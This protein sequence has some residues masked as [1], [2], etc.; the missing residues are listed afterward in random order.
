MAN[1]AT[2]MGNR[3]STLSSSLIGRTNSRPASCAA[4]S[5][6]SSS[7][8]NGRS[9]SGLRTDGI[10][11]P[12]AMSWLVC[13]TT[14]FRVAEC[15]ISSRLGHEPVAQAMHCDRETCADLEGTQSERPASTSSRMMTVTAL[16]ACQGK[17]AFAT[18]NVAERARTTGPRRKREAMRSVEVYRCRSCGRWHLGHPQ[19]R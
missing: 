18:W 12:T 8:R 7:M 10:F 15:G 17:V 2:S 16:A 4:P 13:H 3:S 5:R 19:R 14:G 6:T 11:Q 9:D 1:P